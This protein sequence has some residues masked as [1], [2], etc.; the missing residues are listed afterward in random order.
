[1][2]GRIAETL[3]EYP[4][5]V[6][7]EEGE[8]LGYAYASRHRQRPAYQWSVDASVYVDPFAHRKGVGRS[9]YT[10]L[11]EI[12][13]LQ[14]FVSVYAGIA[15]PNAA[16]VGLHESMGFELIGIYRSVGYKLGKW[17]DVGW[18]QLALQEAMEN[19]PNPRKFSNLGDEAAKILFEKSAH[20]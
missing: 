3:C 15:L 8:I 11:F 4:W 12:L 16:S 1:M 7:A 2:R 20:L 10:A 13:R 19:P 5:L 17:H 18:W 9:L 6:C 14:G